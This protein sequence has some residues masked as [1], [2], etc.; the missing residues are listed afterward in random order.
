MDL[1][2]SFAPGSTELPHNLV[3]GNQPYSRINELVLNAFID[4][5]EWNNIQQ[6]PLTVAETKATNSYELETI[7]YHINTNSSANRGYDLRTVGGE[8]R[9]PFHDW[10]T[11][12][13]GHICVSRKMRD[14]NWRGFVAAETAAPVMACAQGMPKALDDQFFFA[15]IARSK[16]VKEADDGRGPKT[17]DHFT[18]FIGGV[19]SI[20]NNGRVSIHPGDGVGW[21]FESMVNSLAQ[22]FN[23]SKRTKHGPRRIQIVRCPP[24]TQ[25][26][27]CFGRAL[28]FAKPGETFDVLIGPTST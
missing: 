3:E 24:T 8:A 19:A 22:S 21:T 5:Y 2:Q 26:P 16:T 9:P 25:H 7:R 15:G 10:A 11:V 17:D 18:V 1:I 12:L 27:R 20:L 6:D 13:P 14:K 23:G 4:P 28:S